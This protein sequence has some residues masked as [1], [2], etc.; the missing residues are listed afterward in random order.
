MRTVTARLLTAH[1]ALLKVAAMRC[2]HPGAGTPDGYVDCR[3]SWREAMGGTVPE[4]EQQHR[5]CARC[6]A[7]DAVEHL[8][9]ALTHAQ[10][11]WAVGDDTGAS[12]MAIWSTLTGIPCWDSVGATPM[13][14]GD[15]GRCHRLL[16][17]VPEW[18]ARLGEVAA[19]HPAWAPLVADWDTLAT[20]YV[21]GLHEQLGRRIRDATTTSPRSQRGP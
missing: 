14:S 10:V 20:L 18:R 16:L 4:S 3:E 2:I 17:A 8:G 9:A 21:S 1:E 15:F 13:D 6:V 7:A 5:W 12:S 19:A 11:A